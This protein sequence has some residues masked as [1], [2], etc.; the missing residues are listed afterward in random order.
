MLALFMVAIVPVII[1]NDRG[2]DGSLL[3]IVGVFLDYFVVQRDSGL[4]VSFKAYG[5]DRQ[6]LTGIRWNF[7]LY[8]LQFL[9]IPGD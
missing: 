4:C 1:D 2:E 8:N 6:R 5:G 3:H 9:Y 7:L